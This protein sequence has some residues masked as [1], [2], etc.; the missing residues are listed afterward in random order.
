MDAGERRSSSCWSIDF[1]FPP[2]PAQVSMTTGVAGPRPPGPESKHTCS[3]FSRARSSS[4]RASRLSPIIARL[5]FAINVKAAARLPS[6]IPAHHHSMLYRTWPKPWIFEKGSVQRFGCREINVV[7]D[8]VHELKRTH[9]EV[10]RLFHDSVDAFHRGVAVAQNAQGLVVK[11]PSN[12]V[13]DEAG[14]ILGAR[15]SLAHFAHQPGCLLDRLARR[16]VP[17]DHFHQ[18][19]QRRRIEK[20]QTENS[21]RVLRTRRNGRDRERRGIGRDQRFNRAERIQPF[22]DVALEFKL[23]R[24][25]LDDQSGSAKLFEPDRAVK[26]IE[27]LFFLIRGYFSSLSASLKKAADASQSPVDEFL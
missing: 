8:Q 5:L 16:A 1:F 21:L 12:A 18:R 17:L 10:A 14:G 24:S 2:S 25:C 19:H 27:N 3:P 23:L 7:A 11:G 6:Q 22:E 13:D 26:P 9:A 20:V 15:R 4:S